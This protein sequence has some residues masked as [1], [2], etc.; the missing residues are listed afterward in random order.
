MAKRGGFHGCGRGG[1][2]AQGIRR[3]SETGDVERALHVSP[4]DHGDSGRDLRR[5]LDAQADSYDVALDELRRGEKRSHWMWFVFPQLAGLGRSVTARRF[6]LRDLAEARSYLRHPTLG[7][8]L[9]ACTKAVL[10]V[11]DRSAREVFGQIDELKF[12]SCMTLFALVAGPGSPFQ[13][14][15]DKYFAGQ[16]DSLTL[17]LLGRS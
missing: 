6:A 9:L 12:R 4:A 7:P 1:L 17:A 10:E 15:L 11:E 13:Q 14:A 8:R 2:N 16:A 5:F 3:N